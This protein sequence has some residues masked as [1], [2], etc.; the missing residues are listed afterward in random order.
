MS[1]TRIKDIC[2]YKLLP[3]LV[4]LGGHIY[5]DVAIDKVN[6]VTFITKYIWSGAFCLVYRFPEFIN[7]IGGSKLE[8]MG[9]MISTIM[10]LVG[11]EML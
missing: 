2:V 3:G 9:I 11:Q 4:K 10:P 1:I 8:I 7:A 5:L 6:Y